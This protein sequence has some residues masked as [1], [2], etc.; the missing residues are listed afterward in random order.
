MS[1]HA[2][3]PDLSHLLSPV[4]VEGKRERTMS[5]ALGWH[6][7]RHCNVTAEMR[8]STAVR[9]TVTAEMRIVSAGWRNCSWECSHTTHV[10]QPARRKHSL[11]KHREQIC[12][13]VMSVGRR[14]QSAS[15][16]AHILTLAPFSI[17]GGT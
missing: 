16:H 17:K 6:S 7:F 5:A 1:E 3:Q 9:R 14:A 13:N 10:V 15:A 8:T 4:W 11:V 2:S 12:R